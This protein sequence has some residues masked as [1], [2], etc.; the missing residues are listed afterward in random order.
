MS[1]R[2]NLSVS[3]LFKTIKASPE[4][5]VSFTPQ[6]VRIAQSNPIRVILSKSMHGN[7]GVL[8]HF[9][10]DARCNIPFWDNCQFWIPNGPDA[11]IYF[12]RRARAASAASPRDARG[13]WN[14]ANAGRPKTEKAAI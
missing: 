4:S 6:P 13:G 11:E 9:V 7:A 10:G 3:R 2:L 12:Q 8:S 14:D 5:V 1:T